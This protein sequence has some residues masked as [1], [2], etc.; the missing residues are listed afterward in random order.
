MNYWVLTN[1]LAVSP[2]VQSTLKLDM[3][4]ANGQVQM[5]M[6]V[7][8]MILLTLLTFLPAIIISLSSFTRIIIVFHFLRQAL[9]TQEAPSNQIL[10]GLALFLSF[11]IMNPTLTA[12][13]NDAYEPWSKGEID[14][15][16]ALERG[17][18][19]LKQFML[20]ST[21]EKDLQL[22]MEMSGG[23]K[24]KGP[25]DLP[26][27]AVMPAFMISEIK[28][29]FQIGFVLFLPFLVIDMVVSSVL[30]SMGMMQLPP[31]MVSLPFKVLLFIMVDGWGLVVS[32]LVKSYV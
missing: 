12:I 31:V 32:S 1:L 3:T 18:Q 6:P 25:D 14:Q 29:A 24:P 8:I 16:Q 28:T 17:S 4:S 22:F 21:R 15:A 13:Y 19:P 9:G 30:L 27:R 11:F 2:P 23:P 7:Q 20:R 26:M 5:T 10:I